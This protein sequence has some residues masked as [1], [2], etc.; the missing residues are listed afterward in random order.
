MLQKI[1]IENFRNLKSLTIDL[2]GSAVLF[3]MN[4]TGKSSVLDAVHMA[5]F[6]FCRHTDRAGKGADV[7]IRDGAKSACIT[8]QVYC[9]STV[10]TFESVLRRT[11]KKHELTITDA[12]GIILSEGEAWKLLGADKRLACIA[13]MPGFWLGTKELAD[14][15]AE[16]Q[17]GAIRLE[18]VIAAAGEHADWLQTNAAKRSMSLTTPAGHAGFGKWAEEERRALNAE[19]KAQQAFYDAAHGTIKPMVDMR[20]KGVDD[21]PALRTQLR[22]ATMTLD[23]TGAENRRAGRPRIPVPGHCSGSGRAT[24]N[25]PVRLGW[26]RGGRAGKAEQRGHRRGGHPPADSQNLSRRD[27]GFA[28]AGGRCG[29]RGHSADY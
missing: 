5:L 6:G 15:L 19:I 7:L 17:S 28:H 14:L 24:G 27:G 9:D 13:A 16:T 3:G 8:V 22:D 23:R 18:D 25:S 2:S 26:R 11:G 1:T 29:Q 12:D 20:V 21:L 10:L 4:G